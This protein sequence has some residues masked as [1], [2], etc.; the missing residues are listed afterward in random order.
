M[1]LNS[2]N[3]NAGLVLTLCFRDL[4]P[5]DGDISFQM[6][7]LL[8]LACHQ[9]NLTDAAKAA[10]EWFCAKQLKRVRE[11]TDCVTIPVTSIH[12]HTHTQLGHVETDM[13]FMLLHTTCHF[14][15]N[16][17]QRSLHV[18]KYLFYFDRHFLPRCDSLTH[19]QTHC[20]ATSPDLTTYTPIMK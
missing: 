18:E 11:V 17:G 12:T 5:T 16:C 2:P 9:A 6:C 13:L 4:T 10:F 8:I 15:V 19:H 3:K 7:N 14:T 20:V 1:S